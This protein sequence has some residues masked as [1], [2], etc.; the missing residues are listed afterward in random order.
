MKYAVFT[1]DGYGL[2]IAWQLQKEG[3]DVLVAQVEDQ[4]DV[5]SEL[6]KN[7]KP[8]D[9]AS[10]AR[11]LSQYDGML[12]K[13]PVDKVIEKLRK[14]KDPSEWFAFFDLN[15]LFKFSEEVS[16]LG[17]HGN[18]PTV[19]DYC[20]EIDRELAKDFVNENYPMMRV[21]DKHRFNK[22]SE[23]K[24]FLSKSDDFWVLKG[25]EE[26]ART[27]VPDVDDLELANGQILDALAQDPDEYESAGFILELLIPGALELTPGIVFYD[28]E[29]VHTYMCIENKPLGAGNVGPMTDCAQDL[30]FATDMENKI[31]KIAFPPIVH[32]MAKQ[33]KGAFYWDASIYADPRTGKLYFG[34]FCANRPGYNSVYTEISLAAS[35]SKYFEGIARGKSPL[36]E[37]SVAASVRLF[38]FHQSPEGGVQG[39]STVAFRPRIE[40]EL[41]L[42][43]VRKAQRRLCSVGYKP[44]IGVITG[45]GNSVTEAAKRA[46]R[47]V[48]EFSFEGAYYRPLFDFTSREY[49]TSIAN[50]L[51]YG[52]QR[53]LYKIGFGIG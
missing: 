28:G 27:V 12:E 18:F 6:E 40:N 16:K 2:P 15:H 32:E 13:Q 48:D 11:R 29:P 41:W 8:E 14:A 19:G 43:D 21:A 46:Y 17:V 33:H 9:K 36:P 42:N 10:K 25:L 53:G 3:K 50:R 35:A 39:G 7:A 47:N 30:V 26:D 20:Y 44:D 49:K 52:L 51:D 1:F 22:A 5:L 38:N 37:N 24:A 31:N 45:S 34:E 4:R 23:A